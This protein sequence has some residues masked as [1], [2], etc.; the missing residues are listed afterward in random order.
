MLSRRLRS[1]WPCRSG[2][3]KWPDTVPSPFVVQREPGLV[4]GDPLVLAEQRVLVGI[5]HGDVALHGFERA[6]RDDP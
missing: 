4:V 5:D 3:V 1:S 2:T 6:T